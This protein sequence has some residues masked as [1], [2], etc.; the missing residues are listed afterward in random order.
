M[1]RNDD[2]EE[3]VGVHFPDCRFEPGALGI[4]QGVAAALSQTEV[5]TAL[6]RHLSGDWGVRRDR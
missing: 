3:L 5:M 6:R 2:A 1:E 4:T